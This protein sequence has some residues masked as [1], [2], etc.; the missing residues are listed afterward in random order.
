MLSE[1][2]LV[3]YLINESIWLNERIIVGNVPIHNKT[4]IKAGISKIA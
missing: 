1:K 3:K 2:Q 4:W